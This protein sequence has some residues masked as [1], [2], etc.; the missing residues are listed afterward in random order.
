MSSK[1]PSVLFLCVHNAGRSQ[2]AAALLRHYADDKI[3]V[4]SAGSAPADTLN[5]VAIEAMAEL[6][7]DLI[8]GGAAPKLL[9][10]QAVV[11]SDVIITMGCGDSCP[12]FSGKRYEDW[13]LDDPAGQGLE[14]VRRIREDIDVRVRALIIEIL[15]EI[16]IRR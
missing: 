5:P 9:E 16:P 10:Q 7:I 8:A 14:V 2:M 15:G 1:L 13:E 11:D 6:G 3:E 4:R 12:I